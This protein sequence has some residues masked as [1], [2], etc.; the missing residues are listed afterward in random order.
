[1]MV[2]MVPEAV[3]VIAVVG[4]V[5]V[6]VVDVVDFG[7][8]CGDGCLYMVC[9]LIVSFYCVLIPVHCLLCVVCCLIFKMCC[10]W[11]FDC[12]LL[13]DVCLCVA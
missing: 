1:M 7:C 10:I 11:H 13:C 9:S 5:D 12:C 2:I 4:G 3:S 8:C 6:E